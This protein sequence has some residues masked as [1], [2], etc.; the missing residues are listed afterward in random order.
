MEFGLPKS[1]QQKVEKYT[2]QGVIT[3]LPTGENLG[4]KMELNQKAIELLNITNTENQISFSFSGADI[5]IVNTS[6]CDNCSGLKVGKTTNGFADK[7]HYE[8]IKTKTYNLKEE[9]TLELF[10]EETSNEFNGNKVFKLVSNANQDSQ[11]S[12]DTI[13]KDQVNELYS[14]EQHSEYT[15]EQLDML[16]SKAY[17]EQLEVNSPEDLYNKITE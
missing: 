17:A 3:F 10:L 15:Q 11:P 12:Q 8:F 16:E 1:R 5:Y 4:R 9:D 13:T 7:K 6:G 2:D 14:D